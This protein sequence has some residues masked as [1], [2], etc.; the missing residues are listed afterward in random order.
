MNNTVLISQE[1]SK[2]CIWVQNTALVKS[3]DNK[4]VTE[5]E[6]H[7]RLI[8]IQNELKVG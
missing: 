8:N 3:D 4:S 1:L 2:R 5:D 7:R 6:I